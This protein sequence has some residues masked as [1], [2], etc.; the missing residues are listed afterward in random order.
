MTMTKEN[1][2]RSVKIDGKRRGSASTYRLRG[3][4]MCHDSGCRP[5]DACV[6]V[7]Y[8]EVDEVLRG[9]HTHTHTWKG[10]TETT[11]RMTNEWTK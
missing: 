4:R 3:H 7:N 11:N 10:N 6:L 1:R 8:E 5:A 2:K 9:K